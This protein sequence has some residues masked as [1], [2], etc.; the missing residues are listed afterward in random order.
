M[1]FET[2][3]SRS[4]NPYVVLD[5]DFVLVWMNDAYLKVTMRTRE[6]LIGQNMFAAFP[7]DPKSESHRLLRSSLERVLASSETDELA[8]IRYDIPNRD[9]GIEEHYWSATHTPL[10]NEDGSVAFILQHTV[11]VTELHSL[12]RIRDEQG[13]V[14]RASAVQARNLGLS[15]EADRL[16]SMFEQAPGFMALL[17]GPEHYFV[18]AND[19]YL[20]LISKEEVIGKTVAEA[21]PEVVGQGFVDLLDTVYASGTPYF[22]RGVKVVLKNEAENRDE[23]R[24]LDFIYQPLFASGGTATGIFVQGHDVTEEVQAAEAQKLLIN[25]LNHRVKNTLAIVQ[26]LAVQSF[27]RIEGA[28]GAR[29]TFDARLAALAAAHSLL[30]QGNWEA[31]TLKETVHSSIEA[32]AGA[33]IARFAIGGPDATL[34]PQAAVA[35]AMTLHE[36]STNAIKYGALSNEKGHVDV[37][38]TLDLEDDETIVTIDWRERDGPPVIPPARKGFGTRL[39]ERGLTGNQGGSVTLDFRPE[40]L[41]C[42]IVS[43]QKG[44]VV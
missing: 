41:H 44:V 22:G 3:F 8:L 12:R 40:G 32:S 2:L 14:E 19:A 21:L 23:L 33:D 38:W 6:D 18:L 34:Q 9:G 36:L 29:S 37:S 7:S 43:R 26:G 16:R 15:E 5:P 13:L 27:K 17:E 31:A 39:I 4:P 25:E 28:E 11:N 10:L 1:D 30:T 35:L 20:R 24:Y 42:H